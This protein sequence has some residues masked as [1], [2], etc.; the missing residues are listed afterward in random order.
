MFSGRGVA[1]SRD[2]Q[3][4]AMSSEPAP[5][6]PMPITRK[7]PANLDDLSAFQLAAVKYIAEWML[8][9][10]PRLVPHLTVIKNLSSEFP[11]MSPEEMEAQLRELYPAFCKPYNAGGFVGPTFF[12][13]RISSVA[14]VLRGLITGLLNRIHQHMADPQVSRTIGMGEARALMKCELPELSDPAMAVVVEAA[15]GLVADAPS[16]GAPWRL[17]NRHQMNRLLKVLTYD[18]YVELR[19]RD[20]RAQIAKAAALSAIVR[21]SGPADP[22][23]DADTLLRFLANYECTPGDGNKG[24]HLVAPPEAQEHLGW[25]RHRIND[26]IEVALPKGW[27]KPASEATKTMFNGY[28]GGLLYLTVAGRQRAAGGDPPDEAKPDDAHSRKPADLSRREMF[29]LRAFHPSVVSVAGQLFEMN[30]AEDAV[31]KAMLAVLGEIRTISGLST[32]GDALVGV[33]LHESGSSI[34]L[35]PLATDSDRST[36]RGALYFARGLVAAVRN[37]TMHGIDAMADVE[38]LEKLAI[39]SL[40]YRLLDNRIS[41]RPAPHP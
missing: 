24:R 18:D 41:P 12:A 23:R 1:T 9:H 32:D 34:K 15:V 7:D 10:Y 2:V 27:L 5:A 21:D 40:L 33:A 13:L 30:M 14:P 4:G 39:V 25:T 28:T 20:V 26:A 16:S 35:T 36:Q 37:V 8:E 3:L 22:A 11:T 6:T 29:E 31:R 19:I 17:V 38:A